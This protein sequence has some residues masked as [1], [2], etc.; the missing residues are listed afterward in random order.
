MVHRLAHCLSKAA[1]PDLWTASCGTC[2]T[3]ATS[4][5]V[6]DFGHGSKQLG[7]PTANFPE[8]VVDSL[9]ADVS[10][11]IYYGGA[12]TGSRDVHEMVV[13]KG[14]NTRMEYY[15]NTKKSM[16]THVM[17]PFKE[18]FYGEILNG[19][20]VGYF[21]PEK[22]FDSYESLMSAIQGDIE[23]AKKRL[24]LPER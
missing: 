7:I 4:H 16:E 14:W 9:P 15:K 2:L 24:D 17:H 13:S 22:D 8:R 5:V 10:T 20:I 23:K 19:A 11:G 12:S 3:A 1:P 21:R 6:Q 18:D